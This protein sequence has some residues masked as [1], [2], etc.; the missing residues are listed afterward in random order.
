MKIKQLLTIP[1]FGLTLTNAAFA[2][3]TPIL[4]SINSDN[5]A[6]SANF[7]KPI[8][9]DYSF[10]NRGLDVSVATKPGGGYILTA[11]SAG[12]INFYQNSSNVSTMGSGKGYTLTAN[13]DKNSNFITT[14][15]SLTIVGTLNST[16][17]GTGTAQKSTNL[18]SA[19]LTDFGTDASTA[20]IAF[21]TKFNPSWSNQIKFTGGSTGESVYLFDQVGLNNGGH[22]RLSSLIAALNAHNLGSI[23]NQHFVGIE[24][25]ASVPLPLPV[26]LF[27]SGLTALIGLRRKRLNATKSI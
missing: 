27:G 22:G 19:N 4:S 15:S 9:I 13:F 23:G 5:N 24:S 16:L 25:I 2:G 7:S 12:N 17:G 11:T 21:K 8:A 3:L 10:N 26:L 6:N 20:A 1:L 18:F 14:G